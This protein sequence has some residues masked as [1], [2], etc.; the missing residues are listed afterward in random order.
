MR[1]IQF[2]SVSQPSGNLY[3]RHTGSLIFRGE[4]FEKNS[5]ENGTREFTIIFEEFEIRE[6]LSPIRSLGNFAR[7]EAR[8]KSDS[9]DSK[10]NGGPV[11]FRSKG[12]RETRFPACSK[13]WLS[14]CKCR[15]LA[16]A[17]LARGLE[18][19]RSGLIEKLLPLKRRAVPLLSNRTRRSA[20][21]REL[22][23]FH[24][25]MTLS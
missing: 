7:E 24:G 13:H 12:E 23:T 18:T 11:C 15:G 16:R 22:E 14:G 1:N 17:F 2:E 4:T 20:D 6:R 5:R 10:M 21:T 9:T 8:V 19:V 3:N 25:A